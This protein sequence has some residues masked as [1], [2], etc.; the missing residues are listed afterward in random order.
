MAG[1]PGLDG[2]E[3]VRGPAVPP[4]PRTALGRVSW[5]FDVME[6]MPR[7]SAGHQQCILPSSLAPGS[8]LS[9]AS[10]AQED[11]LFS[12]PPPMGW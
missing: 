9:R 3:G 12:G 2:R 11:I 7:A 5:P 4:P 8:D 10:V 6:E 1:Q